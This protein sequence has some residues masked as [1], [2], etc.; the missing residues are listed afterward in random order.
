M[1]RGNGDIADRIEAAL[2]VRPGGIAPLSGGC[3]GEVY[4][5]DV[6][7]PGGGQRLVVKVAEGS[8]AT[9][10]VEG[11]MLAYLAERSTLPVPG[12]VHAEPGLLAMEWIENDGRRSDAG[13][14]EAADLLADLHDIGSDR[15]GF[16]EDT[17]IGSLRQVNTR[18]DDWRAFY[19]EHRLVRFGRMA[20]ERGALP[21]G[22]LAGL[23]RL[24]G[25]LDRVLD[26]VNPPGLIHGD[27][28]SGNVLWRGGR[29]AGFIDPA[30][31]YAD[32]EV[33][34]AFIDLFG[35][36][37]AAFWDRYRERRE[38]PGFADGGWARRCAVYQ[39][40]PLL[41]HAVLFGGHYGSGVAAR[42]ESV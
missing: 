19:G 41:V 16:E 14:I 36:F 37:G 17:L 27:V 11:R 24:A 7:G 13:E 28:W 5:V 33:E 23:E 34:L 35:C 30:V 3:V 1:G 42:L 21:A 40:A 9:L 10:D 38:V 31:H 18:S 20:E 2:G 15:Y 25:R 22:T 29:I 6:G 39:F 4:R 26:H 12:V 32:P 8:K